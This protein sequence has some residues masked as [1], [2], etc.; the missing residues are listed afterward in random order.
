[1]YKLGRVAQVALICLATGVL[2][3]VAF[4]STV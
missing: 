3:V 4:S 1:M 2:V